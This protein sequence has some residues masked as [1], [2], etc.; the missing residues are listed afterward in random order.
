MIRL[1]LKLAVYVPFLNK[2]KGA[3][4]WGEWYVPCDHLIRLHSS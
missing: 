1:L 2:W 4:Q 3:G